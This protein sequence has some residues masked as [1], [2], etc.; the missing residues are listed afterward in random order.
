[1]HALLLEVGPASP[2]S[3]TSCA[4][5]GRETDDTVRS[6]PESQVPP[7]PISVFSVLGFHAFRTCHPHGSDPEK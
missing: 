4:H 3:G 6:L 2:T 1:M 7:P 5:T